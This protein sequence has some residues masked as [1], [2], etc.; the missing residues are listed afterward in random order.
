MAENIYITKFRDF[1]NK[2]NTFQKVS[3]LS[4]PLVVTVALVLLILNSKP[5]PMET[6]YA[7]IEQ[8]EAAKIVEYLKVNN[9]KYELVD[10]G[11]TIKVE[12][13]RVLDTRLSLAQEGL[14]TSGI[15][16]YE[17]FDRTN[18]GMS[19]FIQKLNYKRAL[20]GELSKTINTLDE[21]KNSR[22]HL[23]IPERTLFEKDQKKPTASVTIHLHKDKNITQ[24]SITGIQTL[25]AKSVEGLI[26]EDVSV[27]DHKGKLLSESPIDVNSVAGLTSQQ[28]DQQRKVEDYL[29][30]KVQSLLDNVIGT[31]NSSIRINAELDFTK[32]EQTKKDYDPDRQVVRSEQQMA[33]KNVSTDS[34]SYPAVSMDKEESNV[35]QNYEIS[36]SYEH[37]IHSV[38]NIKRMSI[39]AMINGT[40]KVV[41]S[42]GLKQLVY[43][44][45][46]EEEVNQLTEI[47]KN[48]VGYDDTRKDQIT[49]INVPFD[50]M[51][52]TESVEKLNE[53]VWYL[54]PENQ[55]LILL[56]L[57]I[58][59]A[60]F[61]MYRM[62][63]S[64][65]L[66]ERVRIAMEL[67]HTID[68]K[69]EEEDEIEEDDKLED[70]DIDQ[71]ELLLLPSEL[72]EQ[73]LLEADT[74][75]KEFEDRPELLEEAAYDKRTLAEKARAKLEES[76]TPE[77]TE[78]A[79]LKLEMKNKVEEFF[80]ENT[81]AAIK[82][83]KMFMATDNSEK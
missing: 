23:V 78:D 57:A 12:K 74:E 45:R 79:L 19:E 53:P 60:I 32:I 49:V 36:E 72:P 70:L 11:A 65:Q 5:I 10:N 35:I 75:T 6:L 14:P 76:E 39:A 2:L 69:E 51:I 31:D 28:L 13:E 82:L 46:T 22:V 71:S 52:D 56:L 59:A 67:P 41:D 27:L 34:L 15:I 66:K 81:E 25:V 80:D 8:Q 54:Q 30:N 29:T 55:R 64:K 44:P 83:V 47:I 24:K 26:S 38:G 20:E 62:L 16:G 43:V 77:L 61:M 48:A 40:T 3:L 42:N 33:E 58:I 7:N 68:F 63:Q 37:I 18:L 21:V 9:I 50:T 73:L 17:I 4:I 1:F